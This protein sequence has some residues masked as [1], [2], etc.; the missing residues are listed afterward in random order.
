MLPMGEEMFNC[1]QPFDLVVSIAF[2]L[3]CHDVKP[4][5]RILALHS[6]GAGVDS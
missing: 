6:K 2:C 1:N 4:L 5:L 3:G